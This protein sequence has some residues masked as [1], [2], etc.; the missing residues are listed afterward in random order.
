VSV[1]SE[2]FNEREWMGA[3]AFE[4]AQRA[5]ALLH[6]VAGGLLIFYKSNCVILIRELHEI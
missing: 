6:V 3:R 5:F 2:S 4:Y 1:S